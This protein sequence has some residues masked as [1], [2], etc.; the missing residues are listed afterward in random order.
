MKDIPLKIQEAYRTLNR[1]DQ[2]KSP[3]LIIIKTQNIQNKK[4]I[5]RAVRKKGQGTYKGKPIRI[6]PDVSMETMKAR[7]SWIDVRRH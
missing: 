7:R 4:R 1:L 3:N 2:K 6:T 5:L